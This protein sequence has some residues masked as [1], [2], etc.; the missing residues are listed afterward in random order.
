MARARSTNLPSHQQP[1]LGPGRPQVLVSLLYEARS[2]PGI[3]RR[4]K[5]SA[6]VSAAA[7]PGSGG[8][9]GGGARAPREIR[10]LAEAQVCV[11]CASRRLD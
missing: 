1:T 10:R 8:G 5:P 4:T 3:W 6:S 11:I 7:P 2:R 9:S